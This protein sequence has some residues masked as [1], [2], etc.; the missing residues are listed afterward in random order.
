MERRVRE[1]Q[2][3]MAARSPD[4]HHLLRIAAHFRRTGEPLDLA[5]PF[6]DRLRSRAS[7]THLRA[8][9]HGADDGDNSEG[10]SGFSSRNRLVFEVD[11]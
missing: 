10:G 8:W 2:G 9:S 4:R 11:R 1:L 6:G 3:E 5:D 7:D